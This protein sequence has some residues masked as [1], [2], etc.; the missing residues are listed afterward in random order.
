MR[1]SK[2]VPKAEIV[3]R[4]RELQRLWKALKRYE[5]KVE[6]RE[7]QVVMLCARMRPQGRPSLQS[8]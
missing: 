5:R 7:T 2:A 6:Q 4:Q 8:D 1:Y 3:K